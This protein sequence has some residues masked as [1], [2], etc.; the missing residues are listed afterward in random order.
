MKNKNIYFYLGLILSICILCYSSSLSNPF[1]NLDDQ[2]Q[3]T[4]NPDIRDLD[5]EGIAKIFSSS[6]VGMYQPI[7]TFFYAV[8]YHFWQ[9]NPFA[10]HAFGLLLHLLNCILIFTLLRKFILNPMVILF[11]T[12]VFALH[13][14]QVESVSWVSATSNL[15]FSLFFLLA[16]IFYI[17]FQ[18]NK[19]SWYYFFSL[20]FFIFSCLSKVSAVTFPLVLLLLDWVGNKQIKLTSVWNKI[21]FFAISFVFGL[22]AINTR[23]DAGHL[24][25]LSLDFSM[26]DRLFLVSSSILFY[27]FKLLVPSNLSAF[28][29]YPQ[30]LSLTEY[31]SLPL[32]LGVGFFI[33]KFIGKYPLLFFGAAFYLIT[34]SV[35]LQLVP[36]GNQ[37]T[38]DRYIYLPMLGLLLLLS[39]GLVQLEKWRKGITLPAFLI[40][41]P[42]GFLTYDRTKIWSDDTILWKDVLSKYPNVAQAWNNLG[43]LVLENGNAQQALMNYNK[44]IG[45]QPNYADA[46]SNRGVILS[47][48]GRAKEAIRDFQQALDL[49]PHADAYFNLANELAK[50]GDYN[51]AINNYTKS[52]D[53]APSADSYSNRAFAKLNLGKNNGA[54]LDLDSAIAINPTFANA[55]FLKGMLLIQLQRTIEACYNFNEAGKLGHQKARSAFEQFCI[56]KFEE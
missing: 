11:L 21:P 35:V 2:V 23:E 26:F 44:A 15:L 17:G 4:E 30:A 19:K 1:S 14:M 51:L 33:I 16:L 27:P 52:I 22:I 32:L 10:Y 31:V 3:V 41:L 53:L 37:L 39:V 5:L 43:N 29:P 45:I 48:M 56:G 7:T 28:Y 46:Y 20:L 24:S 18:K 40:L 49:R 9:L 34:I 6:Y 50:L 36:V 25:D 12:A 42:L 13:P 47:R 8:I 54:M 55:Y 38:T